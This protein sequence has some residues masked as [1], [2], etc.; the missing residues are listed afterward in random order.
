MLWNL[1]IQWYLMV[2]R[3]FAHLPRKISLM[4]YYT[5]C[6]CLI[7]QIP[8]TS[9]RH[10]VV[11]SSHIDLNCLCVGDYVLVVNSDWQHLHCLIFKSDLLSSIKF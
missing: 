7:L 1:C 4:C 10:C 3:T 5:T 8:T 9:V 11:V 2:C 6:Y